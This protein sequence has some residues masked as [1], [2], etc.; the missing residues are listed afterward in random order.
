V[1]DALARD[2]AGRVRVAKLN[3]DENPGVAARYTI[4]GIPTLLLFDGGLLRDRLVGAQPRA[5]LEA[6]LGALLAHTAR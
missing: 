5:V 1:I 2:Y 4:Q 6:R 3:V